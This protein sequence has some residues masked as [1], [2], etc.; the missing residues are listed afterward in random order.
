MAWSGLVHAPAYG[1]RR[2]T[3]CQHNPLAHTAVLPTM[4]EERAAGL[5]TA[6]YQ[7]QAQEAMV[8]TLERLAVQQRQLPLFG[9]TV[10]R[11]G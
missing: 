5:D 10:E 4:G 1:Y 8:Q 7:R 2:S 6:S 9:S 11:A 3:G